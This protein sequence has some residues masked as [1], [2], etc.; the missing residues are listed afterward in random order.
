MAID[1]GLS[2]VSQCEHAPESPAIPAIIS[3]RGLDVFPDYAAHYLYQSY[4][5]FSVPLH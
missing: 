1:S 2:P 3:Y 5:T 4:N